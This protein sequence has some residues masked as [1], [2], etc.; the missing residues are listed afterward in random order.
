MT[1]LELVQ[2][3]YHLY[4]IVDA[5]EDIIDTIQIHSL[6][7]KQGCYRLVNDTELNQS[8]NHAIK[9]LAKYKEIK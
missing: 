3:L 1:E 5:L 9:V 7:E 4:G 6:P 8:I 2:E